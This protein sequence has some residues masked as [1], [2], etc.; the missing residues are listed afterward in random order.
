M[1]NRPGL[2]WFDETKSKPIGQIIIEAI[3]SYRRRLQTS[4][5]LALVNETQAGDN[6]WVEGVRVEGRKDIGKWYVWIG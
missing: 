3:S 5:T 4:P 2:L 6:V 1:I